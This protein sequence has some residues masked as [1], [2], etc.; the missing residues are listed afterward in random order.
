MIY[1]A[2]IINT[3]AAKHKFTT[4]H[5]WCSRDEVGG[6]TS[7]ESYFPRC[8]LED[9]KLNKAFEGALISWENPNSFDCADIQLK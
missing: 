8:A 2:L 6:K 5:Y 1:K 4:S 3:I 9:L 7:E